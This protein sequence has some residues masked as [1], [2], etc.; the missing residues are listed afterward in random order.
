MRGLARSGGDGLALTNADAGL[1]DV[2]VLA[3]QPI[4]APVIAS[5]TMVMNSQSQVNQALQD[6]QRGDFG[7]PWGHELSDE[8]WAAQCDARSAAV[9]RRP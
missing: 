1:T 8:E 2:L 6:Y 4:G 9:R 3:G 7:V 5:G